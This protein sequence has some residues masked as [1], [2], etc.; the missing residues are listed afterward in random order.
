MASRHARN[1]RARLS[2]GPLPFPPRTRRRAVAQPPEMQNSLWQTYP[3]RDVRWKTFSE[4]GAAWR[5]YPAE[6]RGV[7][8]NRGEGAPGRSRRRSRP[9]AA[10]PGSLG[11]A[12]GR[13]FI[14]AST[15]ARR[16]ARLRV[17]TRTGCGNVPDWII[18]HSVV[19]ETPIISR[20]WR[21]LMKRTAHLQPWPRP[22]LQLQTGRR[23]ASRLRQPQTLDLSGA[24]WA[25]SSYP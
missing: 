13:A 23:A 7:P 6:P 17:V 5:T 18:R 1:V 9:P 16:K 12:S 8:A 22:L 21:V 10:I 19:R 25:R 11:R 2:R 15:A 14:Q 24:L 20:T 4:D 3:D